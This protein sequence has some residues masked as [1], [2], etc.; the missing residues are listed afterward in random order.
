MAGWGKWLRAGQG[1]QCI[2]VW[3]GQALGK[4]LLE[5]KVKR[6]EAGTGAGRK[7]HGG[8]VKEGK[9]LGSGCLPPPITRLFTWEMIRNVYFF[10]YRI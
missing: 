7:W 6:A 5:N 9:G 4:A 2:C 3:G 8:K 10:I 1:G